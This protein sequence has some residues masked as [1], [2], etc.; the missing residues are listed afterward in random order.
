[1][2][3]AATLLNKLKDQGNA[4]KPCPFSESEIASGKAAES[5]ASFA[6]AV[7]TPEMLQLLRD[8]GV[9][10]VPESEKDSAIS[11]NLV[12]K[13]DS[14][15]ESSKVEGETQQANIV[16]GEESSKHDSSVSMAS[17]QF[18]LA[19]DPLGRFEISVHKH[20]LLRE[21]FTRIDVKVD[22]I[23]QIPLYDPCCFLMKD[24]TNILNQCYTC[25]LL[26]TGV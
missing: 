14:V 2:F 6:E 23:T 16:P 5:V 22:T 7:Y 18:L 24:L 21:K 19:L 13:T 8:A 4:T 15:D 17:R 10:T 20:F 3:F 26:L 1:M 11:Q 25:S 9:P 12:D